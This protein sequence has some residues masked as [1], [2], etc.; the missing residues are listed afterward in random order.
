MARESRLAW[1]A[2]SMN[3]LPI[4]PRWCPRCAAF[5]TTAIRYRSFSTRQAAG[6]LKLMK[7]LPDLEVLR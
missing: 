7:A 6:T 4:P 1:I 3:F 5:W 2:S